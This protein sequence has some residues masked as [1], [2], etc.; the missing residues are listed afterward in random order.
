M[1]GNPKHRVLRH[2]RKPG[3]RGIAKDN[4]MCP[5][6]KNHE[7]T[8]HWEVRSSALDATES[9][10]TRRHVDRYSMPRKH[11]ARSSVQIDSVKLKMQ[12]RARGK[13]TACN[14]GFHNFFCGAGKYTFDFSEMA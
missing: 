1:P 11:R 9:P 13:F 8:N 10:R 7:I 3:F 12:I 14:H 2:S 4:V 5:A 6:E